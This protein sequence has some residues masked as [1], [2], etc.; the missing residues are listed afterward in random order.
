MY[1]AVEELNNIQE[2]VEVEVDEDAPKKKKKK[3]KGKKKVAE[4][5]EAAEQLES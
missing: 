5:P 1:F 2:W 4:S 3:K